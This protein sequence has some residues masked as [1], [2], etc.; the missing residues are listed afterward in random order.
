VKNFL[1]LLEVAAAVVTSFFGFQRDFALI[2]KLWKPQ[3]DHYQL[4]LLLDLKT[5]EV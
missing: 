4:M 2:N 3:L 1:H 5:R